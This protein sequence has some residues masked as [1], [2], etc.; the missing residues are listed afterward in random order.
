MTCLILGAGAE[1]FL[2]GYQVFLLCAI[3]LSNN[4]ANL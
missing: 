4:F 1:E 2:E 3:G